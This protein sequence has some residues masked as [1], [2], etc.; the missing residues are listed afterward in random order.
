MKRNLFGMA[1]GLVVAASLL[2]A[3]SKDGA[4]AK[5]PTKPISMIINFGSGGP[6]DLSARALAKAAEKHLGVPVVVVN[7]PGGNGV[8]GVSELK[9]APKDGQTI[10]IL[11]FASVAIIPN[12]I[13]APYTPDDFEGII[14]YGEYQYCIAVKGDSPY[15]TVADLSAAAKKKDGGFSFS[16]SG[17]PQPFAMVK[18]GE[19]DGSKFRYVNFKSGMEAVMAVVGGHVDASVAIVSDV[20]PFLKSGEVRILASAGNSRMPQAPEVPTLKE[21][22]YDVALVSWFGVGAPKGVA[23]NQLEVLRS[24]FLKAT[25]DPEYQNTMKTLSLPSMKTSGPEF[26]KTLTD[27]YKEIGVYF[28]QIGNK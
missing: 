19:K 20:L 21:Q 16:A 27:G 23:A 8:T 2:S 9:N 1:V 14:A 6:T 26:M 11:S 3:C 28:E 4:D 12:Q 13:K 22:G 15:R 25:D 24:A 5:Y 17:Y 7:K 18:V 10:G